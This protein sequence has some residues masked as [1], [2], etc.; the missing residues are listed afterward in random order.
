MRIGIDVMGG[1]NAPHAILD[2]AIAAAEHLHADDRLVLFGDGDII[3]AA[4]DAAGADASQ[5]EIV[6]TSEVI[7]MDE[8]PVD[9]VRSKQDSS[10]VALCR[11][12]SHREDDPLD[13]VISA[14]NTGAFVA[15]SQMYL[16]RLPHVHR[17]GIAAPVPT[18][19]G[20]VAFID[21]GANIEPKPLHLC[22]YGVM[23][24]VY[25][26][27]ILGIENPRVALMN[28]GGEEQ[29]GTSD[30]KSAR[31]MLRDTPSVNFIGFIEGRSLFDGGADV[32]ITDG[33][34]GNVSIKLAEG[35]STG[36]IRKLAKDIA[37]THPDL[38][39]KF[40]PIVRNLYAEYDYHEHGGAP[41]LGVNGVSLISHGSSKART[42]NNAV[43]RVRQFVVSGVNEH[44][45]EGL[46]EV[47]EEAGVA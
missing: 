35:L 21:V 27:R 44:I 14:G 45:V 32:V 8:G 12:G 30:L 33:I 24:T 26:R 37:D 4:L 42:I 18:F 5:F 13:G 29:K 31:D 22:Q 6:P 19:G 34:V 39:E 3:S 7:G 1:D 40:D 23:G 41:L 15:A 46:A 17:P 10:L 43:Q 25:A 11:A 9:A 2:G 47:E 20:T 16:R 28:V 36:L 38:V